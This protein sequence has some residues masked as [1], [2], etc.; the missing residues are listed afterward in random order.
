[1]WANA[2]STDGVAKEAHLRFAKDTLSGIDYQT[3][4][5]QSLE[6]LP[7]VLMVFLDG[8]A[9]NEDVILVNKDEVEATTNTVHKPLKGLCGISEAEWHATELKKG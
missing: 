7:K 6:E 3:M 9:G 1:M 4:I 5:R 2:V 8:R